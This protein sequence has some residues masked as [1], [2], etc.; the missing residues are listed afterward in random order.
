MSCEV[1]SF[2]EPLAGFYTTEEQSLYE[3]GDFH[4]TWGGD[5]SNVALAL[6]KLGHQSGYI[7]KIGDDFIGKGLFK[8]WKNTGVDVQNVFIEKGMDTGMYFVSFKNGKHEFYYKRSNSAASTFNSSDIDELQMSDFKIL[9][10]SG[11][12]QAISKSC[13]ESSFGLMDATKKQK[14]MISYD[15]NYR[16]KL[17]NPK[18]AKCVYQ[19]VIKEYADIVSF[20]EKEADILG[21][22]SDP[23]NAVKEVLKEKPSV[24][25]FRRGDEGAL[26]GSE[27]EVTKMEAFNVEIADT[28]GAGDTF[29]A[30]ILA[31]I[32]EKMSYKETLRFALAAAAC[33]CTKTGSVEGQPFRSEVERLLKAKS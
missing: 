1:Y 28:V 18:I 24:V 7:T 32:I 25:I 4:M 23:V 14:K 29:T 9:H 2:G 11:I 6:N 22:P 31:G 16:Q 19:N 27:E 33:T 12:S 26:I 8:L 20:N 13:L 30:A 10:L 15:L 17:W 5:S 21:L 3:M